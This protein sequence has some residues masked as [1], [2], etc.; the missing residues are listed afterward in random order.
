MFLPFRR[1]P[2]RGLVTA[3]GSGRSA[4]ALA[5]GLMR[6]GAPVCPHMGC[7]L[8]YDLESRQWL[9]PCHGSAFSVL[10]DPTHGPAMTDANVSHRQRPDG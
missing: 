3:K 10:G 4:G 7:R 1:Y 5:A 9:C 2:G 6:F 8:R